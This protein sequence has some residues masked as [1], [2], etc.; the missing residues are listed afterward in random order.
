MDREK[1]LFQWFGA[2]T[3]KAQYACD[4]YVWCV[5]SRLGGIVKRSLEGKGFKTSID[6][7]G[8]TEAAVQDAQ[9]V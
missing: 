4:L 3:E 1:S 9:M 5:Y 7:A 8:P 6:V 2:L